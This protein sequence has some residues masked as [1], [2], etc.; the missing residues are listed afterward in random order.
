M[1]FLGIDP[2]QSGGIA[3]LDDDY[4][5][6]A[7]KMPDTERDVSDLIERLSEL[8]E[9][10]HINCL[11]EDVHTMPKQGIVS[12]GTFMRN[13]GFLRG[14]LTAHRI[15]FD[16][17]TPSKWQ[18]AFGVKSIKDEPKTAHKNRLKGKAQQLFPQLSITLATAD[19]LLI[20]EYNR[21]TYVNSASA[22]D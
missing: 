18:A 19:A 6:E 7:W 4:A 13:Y 9:Y 3:K 5:A 11:I 17:V 8:G 21:R 14:L 20:A 16:E 1:I 15:R 22:K 10:H 2:G 12:A